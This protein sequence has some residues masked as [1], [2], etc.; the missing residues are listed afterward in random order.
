MLQ[1][2]TVNMQQ[3][4]FSAKTHARLRCL[5]FLFIQ[6]ERTVNNYDEFYAKMHSLIDWW[7]LGQYRH[8]LIDR[9]VLADEERH[10]TLVEHLNFQAS[11]TT[12][13]YSAVILLLPSQ[14]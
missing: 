2:D 4:I 13:C 10:E 11:L 12:E 9:K 7:F 14:V 5:I 1:S 8:W 3:L 6:Q